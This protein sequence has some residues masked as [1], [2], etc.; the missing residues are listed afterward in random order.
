MPLPSGGNLVIDHT[1][2]LTVIDVNTGRFTGGKGLEDTITRNNLEAAR[3]VVRQ[4]RLRDI[5]GI[6][7]IDF[8]DME[9]SQATARRCSPSCRPSSTPTAPRPTWSRSRRWG[10]SR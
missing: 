6:I 3:E 9:Y 2:A 10:W 5:G 8:I 7:I 4:L 1:E